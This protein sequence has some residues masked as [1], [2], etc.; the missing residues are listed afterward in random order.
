MILYQSKYSY[1]YGKYGSMN[2]NKVIEG[3][4]HGLLLVSFP[5]RIF[6]AFA[7]KNPL[8]IAQIRIFIGD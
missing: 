2:Q 4:Y 6:I 1:M 5:I 8:I 7:L 3:I